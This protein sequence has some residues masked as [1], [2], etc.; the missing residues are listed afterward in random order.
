M[1]DRTAIVVLGMH[2]SGTSSVAGALSILGA[3]SPRTLMPA[4]EDNPKGFWESQ[5]LMTFHDKLLEAGGSNWRDWR[6]FGLPGVLD[7]RP[8]FLLEARERLDEEFGGQK[9]IVFKDPRLCRF[10]PLWEQVLEDAGY[11]IVVVTPLRSPTEV[12]ASL[13]ARNAMSVEQACRLWLR[14][15]LT[16][17][18]ASRGHP[19]LFVEWS[20]FLRNWRGS[21]QRMQVSLGLDLDLDN[22]QCA[23]GVDEFLTADLKR[24]SPISSYSTEWIDAAFRILIG[25]AQNG[26]TEEDRAQLDEL[27]W[28][29]DQACLVF[30]DAPR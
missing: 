12:A 24:Q 29:F 23:R 6:P 5:I 4:A 14:H 16:S 3:A 28:A 7:R 30:A 21:A 1:R 9:L 20:D 10:F 11:R 18:R 26:E 2:R 8:E 13:I 27:R 17:E 25:M 15:V 19:R 22:A